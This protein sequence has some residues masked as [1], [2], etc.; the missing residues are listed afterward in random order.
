MSKK[1]QFH[2]IIMGVFVFISMFFVL[3]TPTKAAHNTV[4][5]KVIDYLSNMKS[6]TGHFIQ[7]GPDGVISEGEFA[8]RKPGKMYFGYEDPTP[9]KVVSD[10]FWVS[11][12][13]KKLKTQDKY[14]LSETPLSVLLSDKPDFSGTDYKI[15]VDENE[16]DYLIKA[17]DPKHPERGDI[18][19]AFSKGIIA[20]NHWIVTDAQG[21]K[22]IVNLQ[23]V[24]LNVPTKNSLF[25]ISTDNGKRR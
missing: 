4:P 6:A 24:N 20:L 13:D 23:N 5:P 2:Y 15:T 17:S 7:I 3:I 16:Q 19:L 14:P 1:T 25:F 21:L 18:T 9:L 10:G 22:T 8:L 11:V 12:E